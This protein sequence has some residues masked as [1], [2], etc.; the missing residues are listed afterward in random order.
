M[1]DLTREE[2]ALIRKQAFQEAADYLEKTA[3]DFQQ[4]VNELGAQQPGHTKRHLLDKISLLM[5][6]AGHI[7]KL[8]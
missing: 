6:Q 3:T 1:P 7:K 4:C 8:K 5:G 2:I